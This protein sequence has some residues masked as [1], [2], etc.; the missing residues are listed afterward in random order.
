[1]Q[2]ARR[3]VVAISWATT[4][5]LVGIWSSSAAPP[6]GPNLT[7]TLHARLTDPAGHP[8]DGTFP[9]QFHLHASQT[10]PASLWSEQL[11]TRVVHGIVAVQ[12]GA[13][14]PLDPA[15]F[16]PSAGER[17]I[18]IRV[19]E[20]EVGRVRLTATATAIMATTAGGLWHGGATLD[21]AALD[22]RYVRT[23]GQEVVL[24]PAAP[25][26][27]Q[28]L[29]W[30]AAASRWAPRDSTGG[31]QGLNG[32]TGQLA[33][34]AGSNVQVAADASTGTV[35]ISTTGGLDT[36]TADARYVN[37]S[38]DNVS[39]YLQVGGL[40]STSGGNFGGHVNIDGGLSVNGLYATLQHATVQGGLDVM[41]GSVLHSNAVVHGRLDVHGVKNFVLDHPLDPTKEIVY[42]SL[43]GPE[44]GI[45][46]RGSAALVDGQAAV[47]LPEHFAVLAQEGTIT[48]Q[49]TPTA[50]CNGLYV[51][52]K[53]PGQIVVRELA[54][55]TSNATFDYL[56]QAE[57]CDHP[58]EV[59]RD[60]AATPGTGR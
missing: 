47:S 5:V 49:V 50:E 40:G 6:P 7:I 31:V 30:D 21:V 53:T 23:S 27:G 41:G 25:A 26:E 3:G 59:V 24:A 2:S 20:E 48:V 1:M 34:V 11:S 9:L 15:L 57:R 22:R 52:S 46:V 35:T 43:E 10:D 51:T 55:G 32:L 56:V 58:F 33:I 14:V 12:L 29:T 4:L 8:L 39:G 38:G 60:K 54:R 17:W 37:V 28:V 13:Q 44:C 42:S 16:D 19:G 45:Y 18:G 36:G